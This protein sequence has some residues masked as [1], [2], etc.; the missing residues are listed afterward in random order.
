MES[1]ALVPDDLVTRMLKERARRSPT[2]RAARSSTATRGR[3]RRPRRSTRLLEEEGRIADGG[4]LHRRPGRADRRAAREARRRSRGARTTRRRR[5]RRASRVYREKTEP[6]AE[7]YRADGA[8]PPDRREPAR[9][10]R[11]GGRPRRREEGRRA[12]SS[13]DHLQGADG[14]PED[15]AGDADRPGDPGRVRRGVP[16]RASRPRRSTGSPRTGS[17]SRGGKAA[18][19]GYR[20]YPKTICSSVNEEVVHGIPSPKRK[21]RDGDIVGPRPRGDRRRL[22]RRRGAD[23]DRRA[24][25]PEPVRELVAGHLAGPRGRRRGGARRRADRRHRGGR[26]GRREGE[27]LR[28]RPRVRR[29]RHRD[30]APRGAAGPELRPGRARARRS[31]RG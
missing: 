7:L 6:L 23:G 5:S 21:L 31:A 11:R 10:G 24:R 4:P 2:R 26:R 19:P 8:P 12:G 1:G 17:G 29:A 25:S 30:G 13:D 15:G 16:S 28:R 20:G 18:F 22:L 3:C 27:G 9:R 14:A